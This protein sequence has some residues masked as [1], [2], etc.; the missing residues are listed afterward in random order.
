MK[1]QKIN[2][3]VTLIL[4]LFIILFILWNRLLR[5]RFEQT[6][7]FEGFTKYAIFILF[8]SIISGISA[9]YHI[10][11]LINPLTQQIPFSFFESKLG[12]LFK[13]P[14]IILISR[15]IIK[16]IIKSPENL[17][18]WLYS[19]VKLRPF[20]DKWGNYYVSV[21][22]KH[23]TMV[24]V[25]CIILPRMLTLFFFLYDIFVLQT[26]NY[27]YK[28]LILLIIP[29]IF[30]FFNFVIY[31]LA[32][33]NMAFLSKYWDFKIINN[34]VHIYYLQVSE[35]ED[36]KYQESLD[37]DSIFFYWDLYSKFI[38]YSTKIRSLQAKYNHL[39]SSIYFSLY[40]FGFSYTFCILIGF[41]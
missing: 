29:M 12:Y 21:M 28:S 34:K 2:Q 40:S 3:F 41:I 23:I 6:I 20:V 24:Y 9:Y 4:G 22:T 25:I 10:W 38:T 8:L 39:I 33:A 37:D 14:K 30:N 15:Y 1:I 13:N 11:K 31:D 26:F 36:I 5:I 7:S 32:T 17:Y 35:P 27:F 16:N 18:Y 19:K